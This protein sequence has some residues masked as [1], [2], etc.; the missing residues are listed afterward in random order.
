MSHGR[1]P[2]AD[3][4][5]IDALAYDEWFDTPWGRYAAGVE[6]G[7]VLRALGNIEGA[8]AIDV[9]CGTG[10]LTGIL[11][12]A[13]A[14]II[15]V[16]SE[17]AMLDIAR[18]RVDLLV[19]ADALVLPIRDNSVDIA[20]AVTVLEFIADPPAAMAELARIVRPGGC[21][22]IGALN[23]RSAWGLAHRHDFTARPWNAARF[24]TR[25]ELYDLAA[26]YGN[27]TLRSVLYAPGALPLLEFSGPVFERFGRAMPGIGA[28]RILIVE[29]TR[30]EC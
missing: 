26:P 25:H 19:S 30:P 27:A 1:V 17:P 3:N 13:G 28:F 15:G 8:V 4:A 22:L 16:D 9:G 2:C 10:R 18:H 14:R 6:T 24:L 12:A 7:A 5:W 21:I 11:A 23:P 29:T 20:L